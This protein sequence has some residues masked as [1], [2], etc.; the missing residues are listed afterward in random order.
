MLDQF[1]RDHA[2][3]IYAFLVSQCRDLVWAEDLMQDT[4]VRATRSLGGYRG[5]S[6]RAWLFAIARTTFLD[7]VRRRSRHPT[8]GE[9]ID[10]PVADPDIPDRLTVRAV[11]A[12]LPETQ[13]SA[14]VLRDQL[15]FPYEEV[16]AVL[17]KSVGASKVTVHR[18]RAAF[19]TAFEKEA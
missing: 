1:Y 5:G 17:G 11:L 15:G 18:A 2:Q 6:P 3:A 16:A 7:D 9:L 10:V 8:G 12:S 19:R 4:F 14:L 13:R